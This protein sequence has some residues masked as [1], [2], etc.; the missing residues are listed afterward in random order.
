MPY[1]DLSASSA[2]PSVDKT[3]SWLGHPP[4]VTLFYLHWRLKIQ[5]AS[6]A[7]DERWCT[8]RR[9]R[10]TLISVCRDQML[11]SA[12]LTSYRIDF[13]MVAKVNL[14]CWMAPWTSKCTD[15][16]WQ[17]LLPWTRATFEYNF[18][19]VQDDTLPAPL[20]ISR[21][22]RTWSHRLA[23]QTSGCERH[24]TPLGPGDSSYPWHE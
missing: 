5:A 2:P 7:M 1:I 17:S 9:V 11:M 19:L 15:V 4:M 22:T 20:E 6:H 24:R 10:D 12:R 16:L 18:V 8:D 23:I 3:S 14:L 21:R 13:T